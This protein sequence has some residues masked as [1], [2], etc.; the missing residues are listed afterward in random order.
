MTHHTY[1]KIFLTL[2]SLPDVGNGLMDLRESL[3]Q[4]LAGGA[5]FDDVVEENLHRY[6]SM[7]EGRNTSIC[8]NI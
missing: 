5:V 8:N 1:T 6:N 4:D 3:E 7:V 2:S